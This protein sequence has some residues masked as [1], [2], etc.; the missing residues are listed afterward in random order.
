MALKY[1]QNIFRSDERIMYI[2]MKS[3]CLKLKGFKE[4]HFSLWFNLYFSWPH[5]D[6]S[7]SFDTLHTFV[8]STSTWG[9][10][11]QN[12]LKFSFEICCKTHI[13][14]VPSP[15][16][17]GNI[18]IIWKSQNKCLWSENKEFYVLSTFLISFFIFQQN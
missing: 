1:L 15:S 13:P 5:F 14:S 2:T 7:W 8:T 4:R 9:P 10:Q 11:L 3:V 12:C 18:P 17:K 16:Y 6:R